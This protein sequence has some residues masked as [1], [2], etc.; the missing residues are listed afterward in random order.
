MQCIKNIHF[1]V[2][3][4]K[5]LKE[6]FHK[7]THTLSNDDFPKHFLGLLRLYDVRPRILNSNEQTEKNCEFFEQTSYKTNLYICT[8]FFHICTKTYVLE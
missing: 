1:K 6:D 3:L 5:R 2:V 4:A 7:H 8:K